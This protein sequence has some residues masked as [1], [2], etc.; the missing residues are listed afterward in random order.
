[1]TKATIKTS[2][3]VSVLILLLGVG[4][5]RDWNNPL[6]PNNT[7]ASSFTKILPSVSTDSIAD[8][9]SISASVYITTQS[10]EE[11]FGEEALASSEVVIDENLYVE[12]SGVCWNT[13]GSPNLDDEY[14][15]GEFKVTII[16][17]EPNTDYYVRAFATNGYGTTYG[18]ELEFTATSNLTGEKGSFTDTRDGN[19]YN[20]IG[21]GSYIYMA[22][23]LRYL[24][25]VSPP[26]TP[27][28]TYDCTL[29]YYYVYDYNGTSVSEAK[30]TSNYN[31]YGVLYTWAAAQEVCPDGWHLP[32]SAEYQDLMRYIAN[33][34]YSMSSA[35]EAL[36]ATTS[37][38]DDGNGA[39]VFGFNAMAAGYRGAS[40]S[41]SGFYGLGE[42]TNFWTTGQGSPGSGTIMYIWS[43]TD[44]VWL[45]TSSDCMSGQSVRCVKD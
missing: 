42:N 34:G 21:I 28:T 22:E 24:P 45:G 43:S 7:I 35:G 39:N 31:D 13:S 3:Y 2:I 4:C 19:V 18:E 23:N 16:N 6:D 38:N 8:V 11:I 1:M 26:S 14:E 40:T 9:S 27:S 30:A 25:S 44:D 12:Q 17:L 5:S 33:Q 20:Y 41:Q 10:P 15:M 36:K 29:S 37:W 32:S